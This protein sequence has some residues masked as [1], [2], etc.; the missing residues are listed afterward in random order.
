MTHP[1]SA[2][3]DADLS[4]FVRGSRP[5]RPTVLANIARANS[6]NGLP[7][8]MTRWRLA[9]LV[10]GAARL[11]DLSPGMLRLLQHY[12]DQ[13][14]DI[15]WTPGNEPIVCRPLVETATQLGRSERQIRNLE[16][17]LANRGLLAWR[18]S[19]NHRRWGRRD[20]H[21]GRLTEAY[22]ATLAPLAAR[23]E[24]I[25]VLAARARAED[26]M[27]HRLRREI[28]ACR[29]RLRAALAWC[30]DRHD[31]MLT[32]AQELVSRRLPAKLRLADL[33][34]HHQAM[35][36]TT[37]DLELL[38]M[39][40]TPDHACAVPTAEAEICNRP[41]PDSR[42]DDSRYAPT[43]RNGQT[44]APLMMAMRALSNPTANWQE[45]IDTCR[46]DALMRGITTRTWQEACAHLGRRK[47]ALC[48]AV[49]GARQDIRHEVAYFKAMVERGRQNRL[50]L[51]PTVRALLKQEAMKAPYDRNGHPDRLK[52]PGQCSIATVDHSTEGR[53][54]AQAAHSTPLRP[55]KL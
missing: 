11:L 15:D 33:E 48:A 21:T 38:I 9:A 36:K 32:E 40:G 35:K 6:F 7:A 18:D 41:L 22:G 54:R 53:C 3:R 8:G 39:T 44:P 10:R 20:R 13:T 31:P 29:R 42:E 50:R 46:T 37:D 2:S 43:R 49:T 52:P 34:A 14:F 12:I 5:V 4:S 30:T 26:K 23:A 25:E 28:A 55:E 47:A 27:H 1:S 19:S 45:A 16:Q 17:A 24:D 51:E